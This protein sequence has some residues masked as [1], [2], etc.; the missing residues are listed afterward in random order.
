MWDFLNN[1]IYSEKSIILIFASFLWGVASIVLSPCHL[2]SIPL[3]VTLL[4][5]E[6]TKT[7]PVILTTVFAFAVLISIIVL[8]IVTGLLG[9]MLG[10]LGIWGDILLITCLLYFGLA[11]YDVLPMIGGSGLK[12]VK[13]GIAGAFITGFIFGFALGPCT[14]AFI[15]PVLGIIISSFAQRPAFSVSVILSFSLGHSILIILMGYFWDKFSFSGNHG[16]V[17]SILK[18]LSGIILIIYALYKIKM[19]TG[20]FS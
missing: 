8:G 13:K 17:G 3:A 14:F 6:N 11:C 10:N 16:K 18:K 4:S 1:V 2:T 15:A 12:G 19:L 20:L 7:R 5:R 9:M